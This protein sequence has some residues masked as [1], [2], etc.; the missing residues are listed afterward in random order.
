MNWADIVLVIIIAGCMYFGWKKGFIVAAVEFI[1][2]IATLV[3]ARLFHVPF[4][5]FFTEHFYDP[6]ERVSKHVKAYLFDFFKYDPLTEQSLTKDQIGDAL[7]KLTLPDFFE[8]M[9]HEKVSGAVVRHTIDLVE[10][11]SVQMTEMIVNG[12][13]FFI[14]I[15]LLLMAFGFVQYFGNFLSKLPLL[16]ELNQ[17]GGVI[18][19]AMIGV[20]TVYFV[21][22]ML[23]FFPTFKWSI[24]AT[25]AIETSSWAIYFYK[26]NI[27]KYLFKTVLIQGHLNL[28]G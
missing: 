22:A 9:V 24:L 2:W 1:K 23:S 18:V 17:G 20:V 12:I 10:T 3:I 26:Y 19:G 21:M 14:L 16:K 27:L 5:R 8:E 6:S 28:G 7:S 4:T 13:G 11:I 25:E 15:L